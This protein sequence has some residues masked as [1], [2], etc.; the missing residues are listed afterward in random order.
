MTPQE[1]KDN[2]PE[3]ATHYDISGDYWKI[4]SDKES[5]FKISSGWIR[6]AFP[7]YEEIISGYIKPL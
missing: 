4:I 5:Y 7:C 1:I 6:Y 3:G 2:A